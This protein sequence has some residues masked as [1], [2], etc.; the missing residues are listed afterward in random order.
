MAAEPKIILGISRAKH[1]L[2]D[3]DGA[4]NIKIYKFDARNPKQIQKYVKFQTS[5]LRIRVLDLPDLKFIYL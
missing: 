1:A 5:F 2:S 3:V 4:P